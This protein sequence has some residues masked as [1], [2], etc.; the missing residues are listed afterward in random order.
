MALRRPA[1]S[2]V[3]TVPDHFPPT[4]VLGSGVPLPKILN[5]DFNNAD[6]DVLEVR[7][8]KTKGRAGQQGPL[9][10]KGGLGQSETRLLG[11]LKGSFSYAQSHQ[12]LKSDVVVPV[13]QMGTLRLRTARGLLQV[14]V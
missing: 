2:A 11:S 10:S 1:V 8:D 12:A 6:I 14:E 3:P 7:G 9:F 5:I 13:L 4:A